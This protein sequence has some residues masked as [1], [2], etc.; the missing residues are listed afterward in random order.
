MNQ[1]IA[2]RQWLTETTGSTLYAVIAST[3]DSD[4]LGEYYR[5]DGSR[6]PLGL[7]AETPY[8]DWFPVMPRL[9]QIAPDSPFLE[10]VQQTTHRDWGWLAR[11][12]AALNS[13]LAHLRGLTQIVLPNGKAV[14][15]RYW[16]GRYFPAHLRFMGS[17]WGQILPVFSDY[18][19]NGET[20]ACGVNPEAQAPEFPWW[21]I[22]QALLDSMLDDDPTPLI[23]N[24]LRWLQ[25]NEGD[26]YRS[27]PEA[28]LRQKS[29]QLYEERRAQIRDRVR[30]TELLMS[31]LVHALTL[32]HSPFDDS[33][34]KTPL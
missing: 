24:L 12:P 25:E 33:T 3:G 14:F 27:L 34:W 18:W 21:H 5:L 4:A 2:L 28:Q 30:L 26:L 22:P 9:V 17:D 11:S 13:L 7:Y 6:T 31:D 20:F 10:W 15:F 8:A 32:H 19:I 29:L 1:Q 23:N 16:D